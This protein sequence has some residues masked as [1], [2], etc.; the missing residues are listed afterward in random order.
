LSILPKSGHILFTGRPSQY[1]GLIEK[2]FVNIASKAHN[3]P[4]YFKDISEGAI[5][6]TAEHERLAITQG[7]VEKDPRCIVVTAAYYGVSASLDLEDFE[8]VA[9]IWDCKQCGQALDVILTEVWP[10]PAGRFTC[11][12]PWPLRHCLARGWRAGTRASRTPKALD[13]GQR[14]RRAQCARSPYHDR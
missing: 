4:V 5:P 6:L 8:S 9:R 11:L 1:Q 7:M 12:A 13:I 3:C 14:R 2:H 10:L